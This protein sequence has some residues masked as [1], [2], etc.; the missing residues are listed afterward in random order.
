MRLRQKEHSI[1][2]KQPRDGAIGNKILNRTAI[3]NHSEDVR[4]SMGYEGDE[5]NPDFDK[6]RITCKTPPPVIAAISLKTFKNLLY[7]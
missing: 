5:E 2:E 3:S 4:R 6:N 1:Q 7:H